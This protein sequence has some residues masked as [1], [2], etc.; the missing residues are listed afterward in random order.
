MQR[1][2]ESG[3]QMQMSTDPK[4]RNLT[5]RFSQG[6]RQGGALAIPQ[7]KNPRENTEEQQDAK[8]TT[9]KIQKKI[10]R[11]SEPLSLTVFLTDLVAP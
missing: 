10:M 2:A 5:R 4:W 11:R 1:D 9:S 3:S 8:E 7:H 6:K